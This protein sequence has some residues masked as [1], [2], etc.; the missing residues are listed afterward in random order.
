[1]RKVEYDYEPEAWD[2]IDEKGRKIDL[3]AD[4]EKVSDEEFYAFLGKDR[5]LTEEEAIKLL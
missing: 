5:I 2:F 3:I 4:T 1:M